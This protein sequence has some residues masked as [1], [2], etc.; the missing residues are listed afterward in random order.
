MPF[1]R[2]TASGFY[3][4]KPHWPSSVM[5]AVMREKGIAMIKSSL[6]ALAVLSTLSVVGGCSNANQTKS[7]QSSGNGDIVIDTTGSDGNVSINAGDSNNGNS[8]TANGMTISYPASFDREDLAIE[9]SNVR[10]DFTK[11]KLEIKSGSLTFDEKEFG[12][13]QKGDRIEVRED[14]SVVI[15]SETVNSK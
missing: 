15:N 5:A 1:T 8:V 7:S 13:V 2:R 3:K 12:T 6:F 14:G 11:H 9:D 4:W 10:I